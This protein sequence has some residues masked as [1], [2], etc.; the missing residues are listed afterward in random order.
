MRDF[1]C[2]FLQ[3]ETTGFD[4]STDRVTYAGS[5]VWTLDGGGE[6][7]TS[8]PF[9]YCL[10]GQVIVC[11]KVDGFAMKFLERDLGPI[12]TKQ[13]IDLCSLATPLLVCGYIT[14]VSLDALGDYFNVRAEATK[15]ETMVEVWEGLLAAL[16]LRGDS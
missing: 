3:V 1:R 13:R 2:T 14:S 4:P 16:L 6:P 12:R 5:K 11:P 10:E 8:G 9:P 7:E 15:L